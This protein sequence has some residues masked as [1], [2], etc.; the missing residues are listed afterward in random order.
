MNKITLAKK[1][2][3]LAPIAVNNKEEMGELYETIENILHKSKLDL[4][5]VL[6]VIPDVANPPLDLEALNL[7]TDICEQ[8]ASSNFISDDTHMFETELFAVPIA[9]IKPA[10]E[11]IT[12]ISPTEDSLIQLTKLFRKTGIFPDKANVFLSHELFT[13]EELVDL[14][15][16]D[17]NT[18]HTLFTKITIENHDPVSLSESEEEIE[19]H[20][21]ISLR[22]MIGFKMTLAEEKEQSEEE[23]FE[24]LSNFN[25]LAAPII[26]EMFNVQSAAII[27][28]DNFYSALKN[29]MDFHTSVGRKQDLLLSLEDRDTSDLIAIINFNDYENSVI[30]IKDDETL[31]FTIEVNPLYFQ[32]PEDLSKTILDELDDCGFDIDNVFL[33]FNGETYPAI[34]LLEENNEIDPAVL[35]FLNGN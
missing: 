19:E 7:I 14:T 35:D 30:E 4:E 26:N 1:I 33:Q 28:V 3:K 34:C 27:D 25:E 6:D 11:E 8:S 9:F 23:F 18:I 29:G 10:N 13:P 22:Y 20:E 12:S 31:L 15:Y 2:C 24:K 21:T 32:L 5:E 17:I 16:R